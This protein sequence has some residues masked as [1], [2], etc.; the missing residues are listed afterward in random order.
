LHLPPRRPDEV[1]SHQLEM[2]E[3]ELA[4]RDR[5]RAL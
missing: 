2:I 5:H 4:G 3:P 1:A